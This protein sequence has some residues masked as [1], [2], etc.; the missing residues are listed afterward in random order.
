MGVTIK[1][2][3][4]WEGGEVAVDDKRGRGIRWWIIT[5]VLSS[6]LSNLPTEPQPHPNGLL[7]SSPPTFSI[8]TCP[9]LE[10][11]KLTPTWFGVRCSLSLSLST[12]LPLSFL[13]LDLLLIS[14]MP[15]MPMF[16]WIYF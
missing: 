13:N 5:A 6:S 16:V 14:Y 15:S 10:L 7:H 11:S 12:D 8:D 1:K 2:W 4:R 3:F 9:S